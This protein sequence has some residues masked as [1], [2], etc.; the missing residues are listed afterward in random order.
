MYNKSNNRFRN[1]RRLFFVAG[2]QCFSV[3][4]RDGEP[5][6]RLRSPE[7]HIS[8]LGPCIHRGLA[9]RLP[10]LRK[11]KGTTKQPRIN[12]GCKRRLYYS[13]S[14][15]SSFSSSSLKLSLCFLFIIKPIRPPRA[16]RLVGAATI[17][18]FSATVWVTF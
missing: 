16:M 4:R 17:S 1:R 13:A 5:S 6:D 14:A 10:P 3:R 8:A 2:R 18:G 11:L 15:S 12:R 9:H 7:A